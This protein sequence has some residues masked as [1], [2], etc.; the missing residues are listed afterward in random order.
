[1][2]Q[3]QLL[4][5]KSVLDCQWGCEEVGLHD[6]FLVFLERPS[7]SHKWPARKKRYHHESSSEN[8]H[9]YSR[10][11]VHKSSLESTVTIW[12]RKI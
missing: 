9:K 5:Q 7:F 8:I 1:M 2:K 12:Q 6:L 3:L 11:T 10:V 4:S